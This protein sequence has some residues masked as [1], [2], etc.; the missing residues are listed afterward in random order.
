MIPKTTKRIPDTKRAQIIEALKANPNAHAVAR[1]VGGVSAAS[2][3]LIA[4]TANIDLGR[5]GPKKISAEK[6]AMILEALKI[7][8]NASAIARQFGGMSYKTVTRLAEK[9]N[10]KLGN[11][12]RL[13]A[14]KA[15]L[16]RR[17]RASRTDDETTGLAGC[18]H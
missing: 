10:I 13:A 7:N 17:R 11:K 4:K 6:R 2:V 8:P 15:G 5:S 9:A 3:H 12:A 14:Q 1:E 18:S 16:K